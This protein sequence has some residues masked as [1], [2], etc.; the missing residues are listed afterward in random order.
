MVLDALPVLVAATTSST[1]WWTL[2]VGEGSWQQTGLLV[3]A[4]GYLGLAMLP[5][6]EV[7]GRALAAAVF[8][9]GAI[10]LS[11]NLVAEGEER[12]RLALSYGFATAGAGV[13]YWRWRWDV[14][15]DALPVL[16]AATTSSTIWWTLEVGEGSWQQTG[17]LVAA[18]GYLGL[19]M[20]PSKEVQG[21][22]LAAAAFAGGAIFLSHN[23]VS[24]GEERWRLALSYGFAFV[25][26]TTL[27]GRWQWPLVLGSLPILG[28]ATLFTSLWAAADIP[29][30]W[31]TLGP[32][33]A[34]TGYLGLA[35]FDRARER[36][37]RQMAAL[38]GVS[39]I[40]GGHIAAATPDTS[41]WQLPISYGAVLLGSL[42]DAL[43]ARHERSWL[44]V[45]ALAGMTGSTA[46]WAADVPAAHWAWPPVAAGLAIAASE[47]WWRNRPALAR[48]GWPYALA[49]ALVPLGFIGEYVDTPWA[50]TTAFALSGLAFTWAAVRSHGAFLTLGGLEPT[51][52]A[53][54]V[55]RQMLGR[56]GSALFFGAAAYLNLALELEAA[57]GA[58]TYA[59]IGTGAW[60]GIAAFA[61]LE[62]S[63]T[64][65]LVPVAATGLGLALFIAREDYGQS[66]VM[67]GAWSAA[68]AVSII[69]T[70]RWIATA[71]VAAG[72]AG[73]LA[74]AWASREWPAWSLAVVYA[75][76][77][78][79]TAAALTRWRDYGRSE[80]SRVV[81]ALS[82]VPAALAF[83]VAITTVN[84]RGDQLSRLPLAGRPDLVT[85]DEWAAMAGILVAFGAALF[86][87]GLRLRL[88]VLAVSG[89]AAAMLGLEFAIAT[90]QPENVQAYTAPLAFYLV[91]LGMTYRRSSELFGRHMYLHEALIAGGAAVLVLPG[92]EQALSPGGDKW[93]LILIAEAF[94]LL[95]A[96]F[97]LSQRWLV[98]PGVLTIGGVGFR[99]FSTGSGKLPYW[100]TLG[101]AG[102]ILLG[103]GVLLLSAREW[104]D[105]TR[106][107]IGHWWLEGDEESRPP[108]A[109]PAPRPP[110]GGAAASP[111]AA[112]K[113]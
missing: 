60:L 97:A 35:W 67:L 65:V 53:L 96:G 16:V 82:T 45:P 28:S 20:L 99:Y 39:T 2:E 106:L 17:L 70:R 87:E 51:S 100:L 58:W 91:G 93:G 32:A 7:Q 1:I 64:G 9:G 63:V 52:T 104:W 6:K 105:R 43:P 78:I 21:R 101:I 83:A 113:D 94:L 77:A 40:A 38:A 62:R 72:V 57:E 66:A 95:A 79:A 11:H 55:E 42:W 31:F 46:L 86:L 4:A 103:F 85:T 109:P 8:A 22:A 73:T 89:T 29:P 71:P 23:L 81:T 75:G 61:R 54:L 76:M 59:A 25:G 102:L 112:P 30:E 68:S 110:R 111:P 33:A 27:Y 108:P 10:L 26:A 3:A 50:G 90:F 44:L 80:R 48:V 5:S 15:L 18:A 84:W 24:E 14:V 74:Y 47:L 41:P 107:R 88:R 12:W 98:V 34:G 19:A 56:A 37:W 69:A 92:A 49:L 13:L 36:P